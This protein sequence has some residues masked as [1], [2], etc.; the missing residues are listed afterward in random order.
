MFTNRKHTPETK[1]KMRLAR[2]GRVN[3]P[4]TCKK[5]SENHAKAWKGRKHT[6]ETKKKMG[7]KSK[8]KVFTPEYKKKLSDAIIKSGHLKGEKNP[9]WKG[10]ITPLNFAART[11]FE[12]KQWRKSVFERD[13]YTCLMCG[14][15]KGG[16]LEADH[17]KPFS[18]HIEIRFSIENGRTLCKS[19]HKKTDTWGF[20]AKTYQVNTNPSLHFIKV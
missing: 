10:G 9:N 18:T 5:I 17:I 7:E 20:K 6:E 4:E 8:Q 19:C 15:N 12:Y 14:D 2:L 16:N 3:S 1:E 11:S 13:N